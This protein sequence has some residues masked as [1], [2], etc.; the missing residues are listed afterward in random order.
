MNP[1][2]IQDYLKEVRSTTDAN[3]KYVREFQFAIDNKRKTA[4]QMATLH[5]CLEDRCDDLDKLLRAL[6]VAVESLLQCQHDA[7]WATA[8]DNLSNAHA[9]A[10]KAMQTALDAREQII[11]IFGEIK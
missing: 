1:D 2:P 5:L 10:S 3:V 4:A 6:E 11:K 8:Q 9:C 7:G